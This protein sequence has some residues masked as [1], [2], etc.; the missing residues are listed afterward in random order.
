VPKHFAKSEPRLPPVLVAG[1]DLAEALRLLRQVGYPD[2]PTAAA[3]DTDIL[4]HV[5]N[6]LCDLSSHDGLT[7]LAN[8]R[9]FR[10]TLE[11]EVERAIRSGEPCAL[12]L[13]DLDHFKAINDTHGHPA[14]DLVL[15]TVARRLTDHLRPMDTVARY[16]GEEFAVILP[17][18][19]AAY[20]LQTAERLRG[21]VAGGAI[22]LGK[23]S[24][25]GNA[26]TVNVT[27]SIGVSYLQ[28][29]APVSANTLLKAAD[30]NLYQAKAR[31]RNC[32]WSEAPP[33]STVRRDER[34]ALFR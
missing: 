5:V 8:A 16:G 19:Y 24:G 6:A 28:P 34:A 14:G 27:I 13:M 29:W 20:A 22:A 25:Q 1:V 11:R 7:G 10:L 21:Q 2:P 26:S 17:N 12:L 3:G 18:S 31:G 9:L 23:E 4:Q 30:R 33:T 15:Q 32:V